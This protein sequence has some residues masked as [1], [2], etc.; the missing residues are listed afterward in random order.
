MLSPVVFE[1][2]LKML[3]KGRKIQSKNDFLE[4]IIAPSQYKKIY[5]DSI[6]FK[7]S[8]LFGE[9]LDKFIYDIPC[10]WIEFDDVYYEGTCV[11]NR[12]TL[13]DKILGRTE[14]PL[15]IKL[16]QLEDYILE[17]IFGTGKGRGHKAEKN[18]VKQEIQKF[19]KID[20]FE[21][22]KTLF[23]NNLFFQFICKI[24]IPH[25]SIKETGNIRKKIWKQ[26]VYTMMTQ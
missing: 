22:Y 17:L 14:T 11:V 26:A 19:I 21:L 4:K 20:I 9:I 2:I 6:E 1:D 12:Q 24:I 18:L 5:K 13:Q 7:A 3:L 15:G 10:Q 16:E 8:K 25:E 23:S